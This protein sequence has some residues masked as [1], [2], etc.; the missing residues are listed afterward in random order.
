VASKHE[1]E[2]GSVGIEY[3]H[4]T[5]YNDYS[6]PLGRHAKI[7]VERWG[8]SEQVRLS[9]RKVR[10]LRDLLDKWLEQTHAS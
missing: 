7:A 3:E 6:R 9:E 5:V 4:V 8:Q 1:E 2:L 10:Q